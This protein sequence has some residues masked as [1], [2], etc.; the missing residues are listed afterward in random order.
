MKAVATLASVVALA[1]TSVMAGDWRAGER[2]WRQCTSCHGIVAPDGRV[3]Q[4]ERRN[5][6]NLYGIV[7][8]PAASV[9]GFSYSPELIAARDRG[10]VWT[11]ANFVAYLNNP[12]AFLRRFL[13][14]PRA[15]SVMS[16]QMRGG[17]EDMF[18]Y[19]RHVAQ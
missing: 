17:A 12:T 19:L 8:S 18:A 15:R 4:P 5:A 11:E 1:A 3:I 9:P 13:D 10:L 2:L 7:G 6:P 16:F 14:D